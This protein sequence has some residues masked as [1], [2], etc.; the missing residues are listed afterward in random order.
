M[1][2]D[3]STLQPLAIDY[4]L[5]LFFALVIFFVGK[6]LASILV[7][8]IRKALSRSKVDDM[9]IGFLSNI[10]YALLL[11]VVVLAALGQLGVQTT[12]FIA[13]LG[14]AG[15]AIGLSLQS[16]LA[17]FAA[18]VMIIIFRPFKT[19]DFIEAAG[20]SGVVEEINIFTSQLRSGDN[21]T[22]IIPNGN[23]MGKNITNYSTKPTR[24]VDMVFG[25]GYDDDLRKAK[26]LLEDI[27]QADERILAEPAPL[28]AVSELGDSSVNFVVRPWVKSSDYWPVW[29]AIH[30]QVKLRFDAEGVSIPYPQTDVH[31]HEVKAA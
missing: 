8:G 31:L 23:I 11:V 29:F 4:G 10:A 3:L 2:L 16:S 6:W 20:T 22:L 19:G 1:D 27:L 26:Q 28:I 5:K 24:R 13:I 25:I 9:L 7:S 21:K 15:L 14:A 18:G 30:E 12:S 17:N